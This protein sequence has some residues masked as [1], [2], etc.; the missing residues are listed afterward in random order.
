MQISPG[1]QVLGSPAVQVRLLDERKQRGEF[2]LKEKTSLK[3]KK[4]IM[5]LAVY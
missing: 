1:V 2:G 4:L 5:E 3:K